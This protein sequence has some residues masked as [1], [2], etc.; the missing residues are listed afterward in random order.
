MADVQFPIQWGLIPAFLSADIMSN[1]LYAIC[2]VM[3][4][5]E[6]NLAES[7]NISGVRILR[8]PT[9]LTEKDSRLVPNFVFKSHPVMKLLSVTAVVTSLL[10]ASLAQ[11]TTT[12]TRTTTSSTS[13]T[14]PRPSTSITITTT[15]TTTS[16][17][18]TATTVTPT[19][20]SPTY[21]T[22]V[23]YDTSYDN[24]SGSLASVACS[25]GPNGLLT[26]NFT[27]F[28]SL[29]RFPLIG[30]AFAVAGWNSPNCGTCWELAY[31]S[32]SG[33][34]TTTTRINV[35]AIDVAKDSFNIALGGLN[36][37]T[38]GKGVQLGRVNVVA[39]Q[40]GAAACGL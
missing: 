33:A 14:T 21:A 40:V 9:H 11:I 28:G 8:T 6:P 12:T 25:D 13:A 1:L 32:G 35:L 34:A 36:Q 18:A 30:G 38:G 7:W 16:T 26:R 4:S 39:R 19:P 29:P 37:L 23:S 27:T 2:I 20:P 3:C 5:R 22:T 17:S 24:R 10:A 31:T 15:R